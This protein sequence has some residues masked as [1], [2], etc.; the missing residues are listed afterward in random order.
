MAAVGAVERSTVPPGKT[1]WTETHMA[2]QTVTTNV[3]FHMVPVIA[4]R[5]DEIF[6]A[7]LAR[8]L[9][10][11]VVFALWHIAE[12]AYWLMWTWHETLAAGS[13][14]FRSLRGRGKA[15]WSRVSMFDHFTPTL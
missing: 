2:A 4:A 6:T 5:P 9:L 11:F 10:E 13:A 3:Q 8:A 1:K 14:S 15:H 12:R 7:L